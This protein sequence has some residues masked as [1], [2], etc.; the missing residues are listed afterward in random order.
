[1]LCVLR[2]RGPAKSAH[3]NGHSSGGL[4]SGRAKSTG[5]GKEGQGGKRGVDPHASKDAESDLSL[6]IGHLSF[7]RE[8]APMTMTFVN[9]KSLVLHGGS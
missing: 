1:M 6:Q 9:D 3:S 5:L 2:S 7:M 4:L 8:I